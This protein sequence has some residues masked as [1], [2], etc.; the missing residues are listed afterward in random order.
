MSKTSINNYS[1]TDDTSRI[2]PKLI[3][4]LVLVLIFLISFA[5]PS[6]ALAAVNPSQC[7][8]TLNIAFLENTALLNSNINYTFTIKNNSLKT[9]RKVSVSAYYPDSAS[10]VSSNPK[11]TASN[12]YW[13]LGNMLPN[14]QKT[15]SIVATYKQA[16]SMVE[17]EACAASDNSV[18]ACAVHVLKTGPAVVPVT[19]SPIPTTTTPATTT[20]ATPPTSPATPVTPPAIIPTTSASGEYGVWVWDSPYGMSSAYITKIITGALANKINVFYITIDDYLNIDSLPAGPLKEA[21]KIKYSDA[22]EKFIIAANNSN[23]QVD[24]V[25][26]WRDWAEVPNTYK[27]NVIIDYAVAYNNTRQNKIRA[28]QFDV[29]PYLLPTYETNKATVLKNF[30]AFVDASNQRISSSDSLKLTFV[31]PHFYDSGQKWTPSFTYGGVTTYAFDHMMRILDTRPGSSIIL[32]SYRN[33]AL[34]IDGTVGISKT[35]IDQASS[36]TH[37]TKVIVAQETGNV[38]PGYVTFYNTSKAEYEKQVSLIRN[39]FANSKNF[40]GM[41]VHYIDPFLLL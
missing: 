28:V 9:C 16:E 38:D 11:P 33:F 26:G 14:S 29:E 7:N 1:L 24:V 3:L 17:T 31:I 25:A 37:S 18:D 13:E 34:G 19:V 30:I 4:T 20:V 15:I 6:V 21:E 35:E 22:L 5:I 40:G 2:R 12:Y 36:G 32:M 41:A 23:I 39:A 10:F 27:G 8:L